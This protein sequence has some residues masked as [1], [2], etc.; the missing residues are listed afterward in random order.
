MRF[1]MTWTLVLLL[2]LS[3]T[4][5]CKKKTSSSASGNSSGGV[6]DNGSTSDAGMTGGGGAG[7]GMDGDP[8]EEGMDEDMAAGFEGGFDPAE[9]G[10]DDEDLAAGFEGGDPAEEG[11]DDEDLAAGFEGGEGFDPAEDGSDEDLA[12]GFEGGAGFDPANED[13]DGTGAAGGF[14]GPGGTADPGGFAG[15]GRPAQRK[16]ATLLDA[17]H[18][19]FAKGQTRNGFNYAFAAVLLDPE[20]G[21]TLLKQYQWVPALKRPVLG[22]RWGIGVQFVGSKDAAKKPYPIGVEQKLP[23]KRSANR[24]RGDDFGGGNPDDFGADPGGL[25]DDALGGEFPGSGGGSQG[26][27]TELKKYTGT[28]GDKVMQRLR[29][30]IERGYYGTLLKTAKSGGSSAGGQSAGGFDP[31]EAGF[32]PAEAGFDPADEGLDG[33]GAAGGFAGPG[34]GFPGAGGQ[35]GSSSTGLPGVTMLGVGTLD[36]L[37]QKAQQSDLD[38]VIIF[39]V[40][41][42]VNKK[43][44]LVTNNTTLQLFDVQLGK[45]VRRNKTP[46]NN[47][48]IQIQ[49]KN[50]K[51]TE[52][53]DMIEEE[54]D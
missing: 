26:G 27:N 50:A 11:M 7:P 36:Q 5:G 21:P 45:V 22:V 48:K 31:A 8:S 4:L 24:N 47:V 19:A 17:S 39:E 37:S 14:A 32:D 18:Q 52:V 10:M 9:E 28:L 6:A 20:A 49:S 2:S 3:L 16:P 44:K 12:A 40:K 15:G 46:L 54:I 13:P 43:T 41:V 23:E 51:G 1:F 33:T 42:T 30:R 53:N 25:G 29:G 35:R 38:A 34:A